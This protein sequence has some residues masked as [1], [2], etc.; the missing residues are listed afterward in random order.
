MSIVLLRFV[1]PSPPFAVKLHSGSD[2]PQSTTTQFPGLVCKQNFSDEAIKSGSPFS[3]QL[4][5]FCKAEG[6]PLCD[7]KDFS[8]DDQIDKDATKDGSN[9][10]GTSKSV[11]KTRLSVDDLFVDNVTL[12]DFF[13]TKKGQTKE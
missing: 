8:L 6:V 5:E 12:L 9:S 13:S 7:L 3:N 1:K 10:L 2:Q 11:F 4:K